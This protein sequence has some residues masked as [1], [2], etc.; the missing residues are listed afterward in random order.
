[1]YP[2]LRTSLLQLTKLL[3]LLV[4]LLVQAQI[5]YAILLC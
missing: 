1:L 4:L 5:T 3:W 2:L